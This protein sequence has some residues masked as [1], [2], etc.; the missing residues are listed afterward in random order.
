[1]GLDPKSNKTFVSLVKGLYEV[2][3]KEGTPDSV[4]RA[5][6]DNSGFVNVLQYGSLSG[7]ITKIERK[8]KNHGGKTWTSLELSI[9]DGDQE[10]LLQLPY[11]SNTAKDFFYCM[12]GV[13]YQKRVVFSGAYFKDDDRTKLF[14][15]QDGER[16]MP[17]YSKENPGVKP[18]WEWKVINGKNTPDRT[19]ELAYFQAIID[20]KINPFLASL[21]GHQ[22]PKPQVAPAPQNMPQPQVQQPIQQ[23]QQQQQIPPA[24][25]PNHYAQLQGTNQNNHFAQ[26]QVPQ[27]GQVFQQVAGQIQATSGQHQLQNF[28]GKLN[29]GQPVQQEPVE[30]TADD[31]PF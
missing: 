13:D 25:V 10:F 11:F 27:Q 6:S 31:L 30:A 20:Q 2:R 21:H 24:G 5:K 26:P 15:Y 18:D 14:I 19:K 1:M 3:C 22:Q 7:G 23:N 29:M 12:E 28:D 8:D 4:K 9:R 16:V 17:R